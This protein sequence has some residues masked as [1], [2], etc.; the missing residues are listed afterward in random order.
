MILLPNNGLDTQNND[1]DILPTPDFTCYLRAFTEMA[2]FYV[3]CGT[4]ATNIHIGYIHFAFPF[5]QYVHV[6]VSLREN[7]RIT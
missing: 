4:C 1:T 6:C 7:P 2:V 5:L 3:S